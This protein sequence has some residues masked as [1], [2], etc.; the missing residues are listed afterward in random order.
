MVFP[1]GSY[2]M[3]G[4]IH[5]PYTSTVWIEGA[6]RSATVLSADATFC[7][8]SGSPATCGLSINGVIDFSPAQATATASDSGGVSGLTVS[9]TQPDSTNIALYTRWPAGVY[10]AGNNHVAV[11]DVI[12]QRAWVGINSPLSTNGLTI[13]HVGL[14]FFSRGIVV[15]H[16]VDILDISRV[17]GWPFGLTSNQSSA[18]RDSATANYMFDFQQVDGGWVDNVIADSGKFATLRKNSD[19]DVPMVH[20]SNVRIDANGGFDISNGAV[21][22]ANVEVSL[23]PNTYAFSISGGTLDI[24]GLKIFNN[25][26]TLPM[27]SYN[28]SQNNAG[29]AASMNPGLSIHSLRTSAS[30][31]DQYVV[32]A[33]TAGAFTGTA[34]VR[35]IGGSIGKSPGQS[36]AVPIFGEV[37]GTGNVV[38]SID[39]VQIGTN[40]GTSAV[41]V[42]FASANV[43]SLVNVD[44]PGGWSFTVPS[45]TRLF[46]NSGVAPNL[47]RSLVPLTME[48]G[49]GTAAAGPPGTVT[50]S[51]QS[52]LITTAALTT[53]AGASYTVNLT[54]TEISASSIVIASSYNGT[55]TGGALKGYVRAT[56]GSGTCALV[57]FN[58]HSSA[59]F[60]GTVKIS[61]LVINPN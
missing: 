30:T 12:I 33:S 47:N 14:S 54:N 40:A 20:F 39:G 56:P 49:T 3:Y 31:E 44:A 1:G 53:A 61:F 57:I 51:K 8:P 59:A 45:N 32:Y 2:T 17:E 37:I 60:N 55:N 50:I 16:C 36:Y 15:D 10:I 23:L 43:H 52:G 21:T 26:S 24:W 19:G 13:N 5:P 18:F 28:P 4:P 34:D 48:S 41:A 58:D 38:F 7:N 11:N 9:F 42:N 29:A 46:N 25:A 35:I 6:G 27:I 22:M